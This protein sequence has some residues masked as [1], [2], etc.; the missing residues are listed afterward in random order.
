M[1]E[2]ALVCVNLTFGDALACVLIITIPR[3]SQQF[4][5]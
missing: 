1:L 2:A 5:F 3:L 4:F